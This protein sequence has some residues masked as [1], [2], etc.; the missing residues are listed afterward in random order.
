[1]EMTSSSPTVLHADQEHNRLR[2]VV[3]LLIIVGV[4]IGY[5][6]MRWLFALADNT[7]DYIYVLSC[8]GGLPIGLGLSWL[9]EEGLK[10]IWPS[11]NKLALNETSLELQTREGETQTVEWNHHFVI[12]NWHFQLTGYMRGGRE[13]RVQKN[14]LCLAS[15]VRQEEARVI[16][17]TYLAPKK[18]AVWLADDKSET[19]FHEI[20]ASDIYSNTLRDRFL[21]PARPDIPKQVLAGKDG[22]YW[23]AERRRWKDGVELTP[24]DFATFMEYIKRKA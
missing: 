6:V 2:M 11:G 15:Q 12:T 10:R 1:M 3:L 17:Y 20:K 18:A 8:A 7:A 13:R 22:S 21:A 24:Q 5:W 9:V 23:L 19:A 4:Y 14:W 16:V